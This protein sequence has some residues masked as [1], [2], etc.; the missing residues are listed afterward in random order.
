MKKQL[1]KGQRAE[2]ALQILR[3]AKQNP[4]FEKILIQRMKEKDKKKDS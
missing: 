4:E 2:K 3:V 1:T